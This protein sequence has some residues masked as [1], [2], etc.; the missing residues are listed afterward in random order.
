MII[1]FYKDNTLSLIPIRLIIFFIRADYCY[2]I[3]KEP[4]VFIKLLA[5]SNLPQLIIHLPLK[6][7]ITLNT[8]HSS[9][10]KCKSSL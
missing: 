7:H 9:G 6:K 10:N 1:F 3:I 4:T 2:R 5:L 8:Y